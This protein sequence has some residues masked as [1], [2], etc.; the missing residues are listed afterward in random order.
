MSPPRARRPQVPMAQRR[1]ELA[2]AALKVMRR[3]GAWTMTTRA[4]AAEA[5]VPHGAIHYAFGGKE[6]LLR[7]VI[8]ADVESAAAIFA[9]GVGFVGEGAAEGSPAEV[10]HSAFRR[11]TDRVVAD[12][13]TELVLQELTL[14]G[15][16][17][18]ALRA[19]VADWS[20]GYRRSMSD[21]LAE[22][23]D[24]SGRS[25]QAPVEVIAEQLL[26]VLFGCTVSWLVER[27]EPL[28]RAALAEAAEA[29]AA[30]LV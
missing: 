20:A 22:L 9:G 5:D 4:V 8:A 29:A 11:Y 14:M 3:D 16:R 28:L 6:G 2:E 24:R 17:D 30:R 1:T 15:A 27:D 12:P 26:A 19:L 18:P 7:A 25:W 23:A 10:L 21:L 13:E